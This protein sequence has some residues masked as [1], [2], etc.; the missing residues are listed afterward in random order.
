MTILISPL[1]RRGVLAEAPGGALVPRAHGVCGPL[2]AF[3]F[4]AGG[5]GIRDFVLVG[6]DRGDE[7][8][9]VIVHKCVWHTFRFDCGH[10]ARNALASRAPILVVTVL[11]EARSV[12]PV[13]G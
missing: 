5:A 10:V 7:A 6:H 9:R 8:E 1:V 4:V 13:R 3:V 11:F 12:R 2:G